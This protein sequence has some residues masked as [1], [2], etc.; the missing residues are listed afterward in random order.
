MAKSDSLSLELESKD[1]SWIKI[2]VDGTRTEEFTLFPN[3]HKEVKALKNFRMTIGNAGAIQLKLNNK[4]LNFSGSNH[5][6]KYVAIDS[7]GM[8]YLTSSPNP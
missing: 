2:L 5:E 3:S 4:P 8:Q 6:V 7:S 1:A